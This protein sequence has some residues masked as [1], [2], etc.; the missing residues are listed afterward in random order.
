M[1]T[2]GHNDRSAELEREVA[3]AGTDLALAED[4]TLEQIETTVEKLRQILQRV[5][6]QELEPEDWAVLRAVLR[7]AM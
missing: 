7:E 2:K 4:A 1:P 5:D 6:R 3:L